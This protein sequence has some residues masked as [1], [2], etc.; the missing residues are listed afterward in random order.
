MNLVMFDID[1]TLTDTN[2]VD[3]HCYAQALSEILQVD[4]ADTDWTE[5]KNATAQGCL[6]EF[7]LRTMGRPVT[8]EESASIKNRYTELIT[9][10][11]QT[12]PS[13][14]TPLPGAIELSGDLRAANKLRSGTVLIYPS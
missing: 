3:K 13:L 7:V 9:Q 4:A 14:F 11:A 10:H 2:E 12:G 1:G 8:Q 5:Y 6:E